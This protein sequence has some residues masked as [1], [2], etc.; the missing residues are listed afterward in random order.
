[1][2]LQCCFFHLYFPTAIEQRCKHKP[3]C[4]YKSINYS[5]NCKLIFN[6]LQSIRSSFMAFNFFFLEST[7]ERVSDV[8]HYFIS[9]MLISF[10]SINY[11]NIEL[12]LAPIDF[13]SYCFSSHTLLS[14]MSINCTEFH[15]NHNNSIKLRDL[16]SIF[17]SF[18][19]IYSQLLFILQ[20]IST[21]LQFSHKFTYKHE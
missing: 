9:V 15:K 8:R 20:P 7:T 12:Q 3:F 14:N 16:F 18:L 10:Y 11:D 2:L 4:F 1:M 17:S 6:I 13:K 19:E 5:I 21:T